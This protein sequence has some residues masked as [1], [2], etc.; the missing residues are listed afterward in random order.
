[1]RECKRTDDFVKEFDKICTH[2]KNI[3][4]KLYIENVYKEMNFLRK[5][6][7]HTKSVFQDKML[8]QNYTLKNYT[9]H[10]ECDYPATIVC[11]KVHNEIFAI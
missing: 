4:N 11:I 2:R 9:I 5:Q 6:S 3:L 10:K 1:M 7:M 8:R